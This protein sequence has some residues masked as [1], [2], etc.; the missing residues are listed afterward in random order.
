MPPP[1]W[2]ELDHVSK[3]Y[4]QFPALADLSLAVAPGEV[5]GFLGPN[6]AGK[7]TTLRILMGMLVPT[8]GHARIRGL[9]C[10]RKRVELKRQVGYLPDAPAFFDYLTGWELIRFVGQMHGMDRELLAQRAQVLMMEL[11]IRDAADEFVTNYSL[12]MKKKM[13]LALALL[14]DPEVLI[15]DEPTSGLDPRATHQ[16][17]ELIRNYASSGRSV[18]LST[19]VLDMAERQC[20]RLAII[21]RGRLV[22]EGRP[23]DL[24]ERAGGDRSLEEVFLAL[25]RRGSP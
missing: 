3:Q 4:G 11:D 5:F 25:T 14:H 23:L 21:D 8:S 18:L 19:H 17:Q 1:N 22:A 20:D 9:D 12:G 2:I 7:T 15:L 13:G 10:T 16:V 24:R 6:G